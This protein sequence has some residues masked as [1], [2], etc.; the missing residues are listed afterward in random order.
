MRLSV[1]CEDEKFEG[2]LL[3]LRG[4]KHGKLVLTNTEVGS[5]H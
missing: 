2:H 3:S 5:P 4:V 1:S